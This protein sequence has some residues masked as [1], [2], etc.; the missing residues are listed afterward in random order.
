MDLFRQFFLQQSNDNCKIINIKENN[1]DIY[2][3]N[4]NN[5]K[6][7]INNFIK[8]LNIPDGETFIFIFGLASGEY[9][10]ELI[11]NIGYGNKVYIFEPE[12]VIYNYIMMDLD[13]N[14]I[15]KA[16]SR[17]KV[18]KFKDKNEIMNILN[19]YVDKSYLNK[20]VCSFYTN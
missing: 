2:L 12:E 11:N 13:I 19:T 18:F 6:E 17:V 14:N 8:N 5:E 1:K 16:D 10:K 20:Y 7:N 3:G 4:K 15:L 9:I